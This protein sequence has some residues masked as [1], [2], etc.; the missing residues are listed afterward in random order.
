LVV[1]VVVLERAKVEVLAWAVTA[2]SK[3][4]RDEK[5]LVEVGSAFKAPTANKRM[6]G[7]VAARVHLV[8]IKVLAEV[9]EVSVETTTVQVLHVVLVVEAVEDLAK[10]A[11]LEAAAAALGIRLKM[12]RSK[13]VVEV[14]GLVPKVVVALEGVAGLAVVV[15][16][17]V[18]AGLAVVAA[19][20]ALVRVVGAALEEEVVVFQVVM[21]GKMVVAEVV[22]LAAV[23]EVVVVELV[24]VVVKRGT[25]QGTALVRVREELLATIVNKRGIL[26]AIV[27]ILQRLMKAGLLQ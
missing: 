6:A 11:A 24:I 8:L 22:A 19:A 13:M 14:Q 10:A 15:V 27:Q 16:V 26:P 3:K 9:A 25:L 17:V 4:P 5:V 21:M 2:L 12:T 1:V 23:V 20:V 7:T 18:V